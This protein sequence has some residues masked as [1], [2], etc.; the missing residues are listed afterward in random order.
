MGR[1]E[2]APRRDL[3]VFVACREDAGCRHS[4]VA[5][6]IAR[7]IPKYS[8]ANLIARRSLP[9]D[10]QIRLM[11]NGTYCRALLSMTQRWSRTLPQ[12]IAVSIV[13]DDESVREGMVG[14]M[15]SHGYLAK[16]F[17][18][19]E[20]FLGSGSVHGTDCLI[21]DMHMLGMTGLDLVGRLAASGNSVPVILITARYDE[22]VRA[23]ALEAGV[24]CYLTKPFYEN[25]LLRCISSAV[26]GRTIKGY[27]NVF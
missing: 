17:E 14:L 2:R 12:Q 5:A 8:P 25:D 24:F 3:R 1:A 13:D 9:S 20:S 27:G 10:N 18:S 22:S 6:G 7:P 21:A 15:Q 19:A 23:R 11:R 4:V 26:D 16:A